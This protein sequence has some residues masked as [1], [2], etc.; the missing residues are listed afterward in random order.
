MLFTILDCYTDEPS[1]LGVPP[2]IGTY[3]RYIAGAVLEQ[4]QQY[5]YLTIDDIRYYV[6]AKSDK[7]ALKKLEKAKKT[8]ILVKNRTKSLQEIEE[9]LIK[10]KVL[11]VIAGI[12]TPGKYL[13]AQPGTVT[14]LNSLLP[15][16]KKNIKKFTALK[17]L[18]GPATIAS[19]LYGGRKAAF[20]KGLFDL[21]VPNLEFKLAELIKTRFEED[22]QTEFNYKDL[23]RIAVLG[24]D[25]AKKHPDYPEFLITEIETSRGCFR[26]AACSFCIEP[27]KG[28]AEFRE[29][30]D[31]IEEMKALSNIGV[32]NFRLGKQTCIY[33]Y[34]DAAAE[35]EKLLKGIRNNVKLNVLHVDNANPAKVTEEKTKSL[36]K[37]CTS[38]NVAAFGV[39]SFDPVVVKKNN[40]NSTPEQAY[41][42]VKIINKYGSKIGDNGLPMFL[43]GIN[44]LYGLIGES[45]DTNEENMNWLKRI[46]S[47]GLLLRRINIREVVIFQGTLMASVGESILKKNKKFYWKW[48]NQIRQEIDNPMLKKLTPVNT[49]LKKVRLEVHDGNYTFGRQ[50]GTYPLI[51]GINQ[52][53]GLNKFA[54]IKVTGHMLR[55]VIG[56]VI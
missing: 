25:I 31:I 1:G 12:H 22:V 39:E 2:Y 18:T 51:V 6:L 5:E 7:D 49:V 36:V 54:D 9:I 13:S 15:A 41:D 33:S 50:I 52:K 24:A 48:R 45:K 8:N 26:D 23:K 16:V 34:K 10:T 14:E 46:L 38:G 4:K 53:L 55:S 29:Q 42:A 44:I 21:V 11:V 17:I 27:R 32:K 30:K 3:P 56:S 20:S 37:Y 35:L 28:E 43:P 19:G 47:E 40:L